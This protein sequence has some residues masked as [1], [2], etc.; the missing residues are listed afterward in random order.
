M[1]IGFALTATVS[2]GVVAIAQGA[3]T[4]TVTNA[5]GS[6]R[7]GTNK[8]PASFTGGFTFASDNGALRQA[9]PISYEWWW[10]GVQGGLKGFPTCTAAQIDAAQSD[11]VCPK[12]SL[13]GAVTR[14]EARLGPEGD[15]GVNFVDCK[16]KDVNFYNGGPRTIVWYAFGP[17]D[18]C[19]GVGYLAPF[20]MQLKKVGNSTHFFT[21]LPRNVTNPLPGIE[22]GLTKLPTLFFNKSAKIKGKKQFYFRSTTCKGTR[23][24][25]F[26]LIDTE[27][28]KTTTST[29]GKC[30]KSKK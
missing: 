29:T 22:G 17:G 12:N 4:I 11:A 1:L 24:F 27:G 30:K 28:T 14:F 15:G 18:Q 5:T 8:A 13:V 25:T 9:A 26:Q 23:S 16:G 20:E 10:E 21:A 6:P 2:A 3:T 7:A 19:A